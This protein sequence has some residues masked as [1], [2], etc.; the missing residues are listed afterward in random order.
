MTKLQAEALEFSKGALSDEEL[1]KVLLVYLSS[2]IDA[3]LDGE[4]YGI[5]DL[6]NNRLEARLVEIAQLHPTII[7]SA[8]LWIADCT[9]SC[10]AAAMSAPPPKAIAMIARFYAKLEERID[11]MVVDARKHATKEAA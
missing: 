3:S 1:Q 8:T 4:E 11:E 2:A 6:I 10:A 7:A 5:S 9:V